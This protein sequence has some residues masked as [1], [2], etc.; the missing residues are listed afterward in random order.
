MKYED[1][2]ANAMELHTKEY[3][4]PRYDGTVVEVCFE[5]AG[6]YWDFT[7]EETEKF[8]LDNIVTT[9]PLKRK[10]TR[11][12]SRHKA[13][14]KY[15]I[16][17]LVGSKRVKK[18]NIDKEIEV[19]YS[20]KQKLDEEINEL[21]NKIENKVEVRLTKQKLK[22]NNDDYKWVRSEIKRLE[23]VVRKRDNIEFNN[24]DRSCNCCG[25]YGEE[26]SITVR[27]GSMV[28]SLCEACLQEL[29]D[30]I[31]DR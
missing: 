2:V 15:S 25:Y 6:G 27:L 1:K 24:A 11:I 7:S 21:Q 12:S 18:M 17:F 10:F 5:T 23:R 31:N 13:N 28:V 3:Y 16:I 29:G 9:H 19:L 14:T 8:A 26:K 30:K 4:D 20:K 22:Q